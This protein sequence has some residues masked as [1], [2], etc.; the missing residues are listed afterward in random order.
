LKRFNTQLLFAY[1]TLTA[2]IALF[3]D[4]LP[5]KNERAF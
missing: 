2:Q 5:Q 4:Y 3:C 1:G